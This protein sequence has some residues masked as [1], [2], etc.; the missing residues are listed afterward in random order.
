MNA[1]SRWNQ[2]NELEDLQHS[3]VSLFCRSCVDWPEQHL[4]APQ[5]IPRVALRE[6]ARGH[7]LKAELPGVAHEAKS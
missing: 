2:L 7:L 6:N 3:L 4:R 1:L 5:R